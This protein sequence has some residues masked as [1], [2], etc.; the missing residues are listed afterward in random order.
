MPLY[1]LIFDPIILEQQIQPALSASWRQQRFE[2]CIAIAV[3]ILPRA[4]LFR[5]RCH[6]GPEEPILDKVLHG[7]SFDRRL[8]QALAGELLLFGAA[9]MPELQIA[10]ETL[11]S[12]LAS[13]A[14]DG[15]PRERFP[16]IHQA[17][18]GS[19]D[20]CFGLHCYR[21]DQAGYNNAQDVR[22]LSA[23]LA[24]QRPEAW[25]TSALAGIRELANEEERME[26]LEF[27]RYCFPAFQAMYRNAERQGQ[28]IVCE[29][30]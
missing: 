10:P 1:Y 12:I 6:A 18:Y 19:R 25:T 13:S 5:E 23:Y 26:E 30:M 11:C 20:L 9:E 15:V 4:R 29:R 3:S 8:W 14:G 2:P 24:E 17:C 28:A 21:P 27:A 16:A 22:R 7:L